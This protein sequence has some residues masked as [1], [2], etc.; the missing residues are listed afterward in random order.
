MFELNFNQ[1][2][3]K[4]KHNLV[5]IESSKNDSDKVIDLIIYKNIKL[6]VF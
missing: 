3:N 6:N 1:Y 5:P 2:K 4:W